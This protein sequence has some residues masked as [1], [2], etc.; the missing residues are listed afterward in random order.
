MG[1]RRNKNR[2]N[3]IFHWPWPELGRDGS[4]CINS[5]YGGP[6]VRIFTTF[7]FKVFILN[8]RKCEAFILS[9][10]TNDHVHNNRGHVEKSNPKVCIFGA[11]VL[12]NIFVTHT[13]TLGFMDYIPFLQGMI[14]YQ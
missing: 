6:F 12:S 3:T 11:D 5:R 8:S 4:R 14:G 7:S 10:G 9:Y 13:F 2:Q 1:N